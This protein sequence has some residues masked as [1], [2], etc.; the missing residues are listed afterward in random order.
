MLRLDSFDHSGAL[1]SNE[2]DFEF[3]F[4]TAISSSRRLKDEGNRSKNA[5]PGNS[6]PLR[7]K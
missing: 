4:K 7:L 5:I 2:S 1:L 6:K 3:F